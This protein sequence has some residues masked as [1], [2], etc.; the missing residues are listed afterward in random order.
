MLLSSPFTDEKLE[1]IQE[2][3]HDNRAGTLPGGSDATAHI[4][5]PS[6]AA[7]LSLHLDFIITPQSVWHGALIGVIIN[8]DLSLKPSWGLVLKERSLGS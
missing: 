8:E 3:V 2:L 4:L 5:S 7:S 1:V 6:R